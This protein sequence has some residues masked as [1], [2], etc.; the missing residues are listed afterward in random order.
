MIEP[1]VFIE[2]E[3]RLSKEQIETEIP[4]QACVSYAYA[5]C[6]TDEADNFIDSLYVAARGCGRA[7]SADPAEDIVRVNPPD[8]YKIAAVLNDREGAA[9]KTA[10]LNSFVW[11]AMTNPQWLVFGF[12]GVED[13]SSWCWAHID[14]LALH[15]QFVKSQGEK[16]WVTTF[17]NAAR[18][19][20]QRQCASV[21]EHVTDDSISLSCTDTLSNDGLY[22]HPLTACRKI[23]AG[24]TSILAQSE[25]GEAVW[26]SVKN[27]SIYFA[28]VPD[29]PRVQLLNGGTVRSIRGSAA[30]RHSGPKQEPASGFSP[31]GRKLQPGPG[32]DRGQTSGVI[33]S[34]DGKKRRVRVKE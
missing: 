21:T 25:S 18:Y 30:P 10:T 2:E 34:G 15:W 20:A 1:M 19:I 7:T 31:R 14:T 26:H 8:I 4:G 13:D 3:L 9:L 28:I 29:G 33:L 11:H 32:G 22:N 5:Y 27:D 17:G 23:P 16:L 6:Q 12:H 24:W